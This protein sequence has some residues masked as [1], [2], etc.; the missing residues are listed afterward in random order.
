MKTPPAQ[1]TR[2][3]FLTSTL[4][5]G[6]ALPLVSR[7][8]AATGHRPAP[9]KILVLGGTGFLGPHFVRAALANGHTVTLFNRGKTNSDLFQ[10]LEKL[11]GDREKGDL[12]ALKGR[13]F[14][15]V[16]DTSGYVPA[17]V[18]A[19]ATLLRD[20]VAH[21]Q[22]ISTISVYG[23]FGTRPDSIDETT[24]VATVEDDKVADVNAIRQAMPFY[25]PLKARCEA[26]AEAAMPGRV[27]NL[28]PGLIVGPG[29]T[30]DRFTW[31]PWRM[32]QGGEVLAPGDQDG[33]SQFLDV[34]DLAAWMLLVV[35]QNTV[36]VYNAVGFAGRVS[37]G[38]VLAACKCATSKPVTLTWASEEFLQQNEVRPY[39]EM[40]LWIPREGRSMVQNQKAMAKGL[41]FRPIADTVRDT[42]AWARTERGD[43][44]FTRTGLRTEREQ[45]LLKAWHERDV[46]GAGK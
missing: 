35:E 26:A 22:F 46:Q 24:D 41:T 2:R 36:G 6:A 12:E 1:P 29:D 27:S 13:D 9:K 20:R 19:T 10:E 40:P 7:L 37:L 32:D 4:A 30:S 33:H 23:A 16:I 45:E 25:G 39:M 43:K 42:L 21:Y 8:P 31:W 15:A 11:R 18:E 28:R 17:H 44:P 38:E 3:S 34:R 14:D 5:A